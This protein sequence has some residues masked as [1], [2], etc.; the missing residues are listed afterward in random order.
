MATFIEAPVFGDLANRT[1]TPLVAVHGG[2]GLSHDALS[3]SFDLADASIPVVFYDQIGNARSTHLREKPTTFWT[4][5]LFIDELE[6]LL[7]H[8][9]LQDNFSLVYHSW[10]GILVSEFEVRRQPPGLQKLILTNKLGASSLWDKSNAQLDPKAFQAALRGFH[11]HG[12]SVKPMPKEFIYSLDQVFGKN[13]DAAVA[14]A[15]SDWSIIDRLHLV[16]VLTLVINGRKDISQ[17]FVVVPFFE[18]IRK[19]K[20]VTFENSSHTPFWKERERYM[21]ARCW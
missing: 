3:P 20:W 1:H 13:G 9:G 2:P 12:C 21:Q 15:P 11:G 17:D 16:C 5:D 14:S 19:T 18:L 4:I 6:N 7:S 8:L 10:G